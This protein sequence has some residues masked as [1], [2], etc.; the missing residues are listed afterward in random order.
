MQGKPGN[1][2]KLIPL[3]CFFHLSKQ[4]YAKIVIFAS[5]KWIDGSVNYSKLN[6]YKFT[7]KSLSIT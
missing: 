4:N 2:E 7:T 6:D 5:G 1:S 3:L